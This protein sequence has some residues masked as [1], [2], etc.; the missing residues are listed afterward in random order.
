MINSDNEMKSRIK[1]FITLG[2]CLKNDKILVGLHTP[3]DLLNNMFT[4]RWNI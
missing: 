3:I 1:S 4:Y 2:I